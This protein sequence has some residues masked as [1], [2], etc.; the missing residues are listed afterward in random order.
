RIGAAD[1]DITGRR[2]HDRAAVAAIRSGDQ[3]VA[4]AR[5]DAEGE[6]YVGGGDRYGAAVA[7]TARA[8]R[9][10]S[11]GADREGRGVEAGL[12]RRVGR[13]DRD[14][15]AADQLHR[16]AIAGAG[17]AV[18]PAIR[19]QVPGDGDVAGGI[20]DYG[21]AIRGERAAARSVDVDVGGRSQAR[22]A[23][24]LAIADGGPDGE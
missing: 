2:Q 16:A 1:G 5:E 15:A 14:G 12:R 24:R 7:G 20:D 8:V 23:R 22:C 3:R 17:G 19:P 4:A 9:I 6:S 10:D 21:A 11:V 18:E 13:V